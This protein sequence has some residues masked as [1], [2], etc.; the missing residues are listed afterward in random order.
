MDEL[1]ESYSRRAI[2]VARKAVDHA[3]DAEVEISDVVAYMV[4]IYGN[5]EYEAGFDD[6]RKLMVKEEE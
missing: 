2:G 3:K 6:A 1:R 5:R 4:A